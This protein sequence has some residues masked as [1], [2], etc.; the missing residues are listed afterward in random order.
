[1]RT[2]GSSRLRTHNILIHMRK[3]NILPIFILVLFLLGCE[4]GSETNTSQIKIG[5][6]NNMVIYTYDTLLIGYYNSPRYF[7]LDLD[8]NGINDIQFESEVWGSSAIGNHPCSRIKSLHENAMIYVF[9]KND[10]S[11]VNLDTIV[12]YGGT[13]SVV[14][15][16]YINNTCHRIDEN[17]TIFGITPSAKVKPLNK[18]EV[19]KLGDTYIAD[20]IT[21]IDDSYQFPPALVEEND[22]TTIYSIYSFYNN[23]NEFPL[24]EITYIGIKLVNES[25]LGWIKI[26]IVDKNR[27][28]ILES[29][30]QK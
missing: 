23:C 19:I 30:I 1:L 10:T 22:D 27:I 15:G 13:N 9:Y 28:S 6:Y 29:G 18:G 4:K 17:D 3:K 5:D 21:L 24:D 8:K 7:N 20:T 14:I 25:R 26:S 12:Y 16:L 11:F 2:I